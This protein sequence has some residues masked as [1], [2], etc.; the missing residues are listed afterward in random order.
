M[1]RFRFVHDNQVD[2]PVKRMCELVE[3]PRS[4]FYAWT[5]RTPWARD[6]ADE[7]LL[8][9]IRDIYRRSRNTYGVP[10]M[11]GQLQRR[12]HRI[13]RSGVARLMRADGLVGAHAPKKWRRGRPDAGGAPDL[14]EPGLPR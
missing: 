14:F 13:A 7:V 9:T 5:T 8:E 6:R 12:G 2:L 4:S 1:I 10:R 11:L 3:V